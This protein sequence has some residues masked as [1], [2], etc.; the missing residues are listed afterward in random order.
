MKPSNEQLQAILDAVPIPLV[1]TRMADGKVLYANRHL[2]SLMGLEPSELVGR[3]SPDFY[4]DLEDRKIIVEKLKVDGRLE[5]HQVRLKTND[6]RLIWTLFSLITMEIDGENAIVGGLYD[7]TTRKETED[8]LRDS[9]TLFRQLTDNINEVF[10]IRD[11][12]R[13]RVIYISPAYER[14]FGRDSEE[15]LRDPD[16]LM[17]AV[18]KDDRDHLE[19]HIAQELQTGRRVSHEMEFRI[20]RGDGE[21]RWM[22]TRIFPIR[23]DEGE[24]ER[25]CGVSE[26]FTERKEVQASLERANRDLKE[27]QSQLIQSEKMAALGNLVAGIAH[28]INTPVG[29]INS[30][31]DTLV[32]AV[33]KLTASLESSKALSEDRSLQPTLKVISDANRVISTG[34]ERVMEIVRGLRSF[35]RLDEAEMKEVDIHRGIDDTLPL[36]HHDLKDR[37]KVVKDY[38]EIPTIVCF[39]SRLNQVFLN[40]LVNAAHAIKGD[41]SITISTS[42]RA[43]KVHVAIKDT[44]VGIPPEN[45]DKIFDPG[46]TTKG[47]GVG[48]GLGLSICYQIV[49]D[50]RGEI[51][52][53]SRVEEG[54]TFTVV[55]PTDLEEGPG[56]QT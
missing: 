16:A 3:I 22:R 7:I 17:D 15:I 9:E 13:D 21:V 5:N 48:T 1:I 39:P 28:E 33:Q 49:E 56:T 30:M 8:A 54:T 10:W 27:T 34:T 51:Q 2:G 50:H 14:I 20:L 42:E 45:L 46:F 44:G 26:D 38:G 24:V 19:R 4:H 25:V 41:G 35:A 23:N 40:I 12:K 47:V 43:G 32:R 36:I 55:L 31:H 11:L 37:I 18:H 52:V 29:A 53:E 6:G